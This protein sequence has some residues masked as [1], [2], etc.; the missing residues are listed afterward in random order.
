MKQIR[1][2]LEQNR[3]CKKGIPGVREILLAVQKKQD[4][5]TRRQVSLKSQTL[6]E[7]KP[8]RKVTAAKYECKV[9]HEYRLSPHRGVFGKM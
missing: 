4:D 6:N 7:L 3:G 1:V 9:A 2:I 8:H 5:A